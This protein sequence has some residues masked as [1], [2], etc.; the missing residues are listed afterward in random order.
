MLDSHISMTSYCIHSMM[1]N[2]SGTQDTIS[3]SFLNSPQQIWILTP[4]S[5][6]SLLTLGSSFWYTFLHGTQWPLQ[7]VILSNWFYNTCSKY[8]LRYS[9]YV[10]PS[11]S[12]FSLSM[13][14]VA[15]S[16]QFWTVSHLPCTV[17]KDAS[18]WD[19][20]KCY[21]GGCPWKANF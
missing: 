8:L 21:L 14:T 5:S 3:L 7:E 20:K 12:L 15:C 18:P 11:T 10:L 16:G 9:K 19:G 17:T 6:N 13:I 1:I 2:H 4:F